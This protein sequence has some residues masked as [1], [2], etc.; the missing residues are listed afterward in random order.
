MME[1]ERK[2]IWLLHVWRRPATRTNDRVLREGRWSGEEG[3]DMWALLGSDV[4]ERAK[5][6]MAILVNM[7]IQ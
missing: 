5:T 1:E 3:Y 7:K 4:G 6:Y 2:S